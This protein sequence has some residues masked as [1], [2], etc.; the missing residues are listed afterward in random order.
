[1][2]FA[3]SSTESPESASP[4]KSSHYK[5]KAV[6]IYVILA[7]LE[8]SVFSV[9]ARNILWIWFQMK[10]KLVLSLRANGSP[11]GKTKIPWG[12]WTLRLAVPGTRIAEAGGH[13]GFKP[14]SG[15]A[16]LSFLGFSLPHK[17]ALTEGILE[18]MLQHAC[19][20]HPFSIQATRTEA[21]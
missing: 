5:Y 15:E 12:L 2:D 21:T 7:I 20:Y 14:G 11:R 9:T 4:P 8:F 1:M 18:Q 17:D 13:R 16:C 6:W 3:K 10:S 19:C